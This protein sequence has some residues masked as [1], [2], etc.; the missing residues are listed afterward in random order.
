MRP[1]KAFGIDFEEAEVISTNDQFLSDGS[2]S[3]RNLVNAMKHYDKLTNKL[4]RKEYV[5]TESSSNTE[6]I[7]E[8]QAVG[9]NAI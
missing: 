2:G 7:L 3:F 8:Y 6:L 5:V 4:I 1:H 9:N